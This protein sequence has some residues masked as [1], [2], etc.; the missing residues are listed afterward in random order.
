MNFQELCQ[1]IYID[2]EVEIN[3]KELSDEI[4][5]MTAEQ[6]KENVKAVILNE[7]ADTVI[8]RII[9]LRAALYVQDKE[10][11]A[12][13]DDTN[14]NQ[15]LI[16]EYLSDKG[17]ISDIQIN[18]DKVSVVFKYD[19]ES[20]LFNAIKLQTNLNSDNVV[21][22]FVNKNG[23]NNPE[24]VVIVSSV[25]EYIDFIDSFESADYVSRGQ[26]DCTY[27][28]LPSL[29]RLYNDHYDRYGAAYLTDFEKKIIH[30]DSSVIEHSKEEKRAYAQHFGIPT[31][32]LDF[33]E[34]HLISLLFAVEDYSYGSQHSIV[35]FVNSLEWNASKISTREKLIDFSN[36][37][38]VELKESRYG[39]NCFF[40]SVGNNNER[41]H[42]QKGCFLKVAEASYKSEIPEMVSSYSKIAIIDKN[43]KESI[44]KDLL[45]LGITFE[46]IY[47][48]IDNMTKTIRFIKENMD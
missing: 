28:L 6:I 42:F 16:R 35:Y 9:E 43:A 8:D 20:K 15:E 44:L 2:H 27:E 46:N 10:T 7:K 39:S 45:K 31:N 4:M 5:G 32:Y 48:D 25:K 19:E 24:D 18:N 29:Y 23:I 40:I 11:T 22:Y 12:V 26:K 17:D 41:I 36:K 21:D 34:A 13:E 38:E 3:E 1:E 47:P 33:T 30:Y 14:T 37:A